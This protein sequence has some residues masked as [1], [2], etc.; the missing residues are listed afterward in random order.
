IVPEVA[1]PK[2]PF[3]GSKRHTKFD[4]FEVYKYINPI[5]LFRGQWQFRRPEGMSN[6]EFASWLESEVQPIFEKQKRDLASII[7]PKV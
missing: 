4:L 2:L 1:S 5:A 6:P 3:Y 7:K